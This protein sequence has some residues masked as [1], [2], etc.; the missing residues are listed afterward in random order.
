MGRYI[1]FRFF[2]FHFFGSSTSF[3]YILYFMKE[4]EDGIIPWLI[5]TTFSIS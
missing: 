1:R 4:F 3:C 2:F 5:S